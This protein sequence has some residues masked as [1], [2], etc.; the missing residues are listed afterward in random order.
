MMYT[1]NNSQTASYS[2]DLVSMRVHYRSLECT[3][4]AIQ[5]PQIIRPQ[6][7]NFLSRAFGFSVFSSYCGNI[8][9]RNVAHVQQ[10]SSISL[11]G[12]VFGMG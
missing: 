7:S 11:Y 3:P 5:F 9:K 2:I 12:R 4:T 6:H 1:Y 8:L 10:V